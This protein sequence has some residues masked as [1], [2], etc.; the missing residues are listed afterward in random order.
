M[1]SPLVYCINV[2]DS[3]DRIELSLVLTIVVGLSGW[4]YSDDG[5]LN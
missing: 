2:L 5:A 4:T 1:I 3:L